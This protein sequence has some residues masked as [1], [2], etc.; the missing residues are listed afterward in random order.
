MN[1]ILYIVICALILLVAIVIYAYASLM[2]YK[3]NK[4]ISGVISEYTTKYERT[5]NWVASLEERINVLNKSV[6]GFYDANQAI[7]DLNDELI[8][9]NQELFV[10]IQKMEMAIENLKENNE[11]VMEEE[12]T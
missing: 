10:E 9:D 3:S 12:V 6:N 4:E 7:L 11:A 5:D 2:M 8:K 1:D